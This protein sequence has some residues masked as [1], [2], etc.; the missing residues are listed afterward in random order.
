MRKK[1]KLPA[2]LA[3]KIPEKKGEAL[4]FADGTWLF[5]TDSGLYVFPATGL[6]SV[7]GIDKTA[8]ADAF[9]AV[10]LAPH[11]STEATEG[12]ENPKE[13]LPPVGETCWS[14]HELQQIL[15]NREADVLRVEFADPAQTPV[16][17]KN[18]EGEGLKAFGDK[19]R[20][21]LNRSQIFTQFATVPSGTKVRVTIRE[22]ADHTRF[23]EV[24]AFGALEPRD[25][26]FLDV[27]EADVRDAAG[28]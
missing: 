14:W 1:P 23:S 26:A 19:T 12:L 15:W 3:D 6:T 22:R 2:E 4:H 9:P 5:A 27:F 7:S 10:G 11:E 24:V 25:Q 13:N 17:W 16:T 18:P 28:L 8:S 21:C 20:R